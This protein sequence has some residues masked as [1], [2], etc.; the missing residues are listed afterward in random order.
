MEQVAIEEEHRA[1]SRLHGDLPRV[2]EAV[3]LRR[4]VELIRTIV[5]SQGIEVAR[6]VRPGQYPKAAV[7]DRRVVDGDP[8]TDQ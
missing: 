7:L 1:C 5:R 3:A 6:P 4:R 8:S 2:L